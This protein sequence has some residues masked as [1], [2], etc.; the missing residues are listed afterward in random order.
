ML[1][2]KWS[3]RCSFGAIVAA[4]FFVFEPTA[5]A[6]IV[7]E[8]TD[9]AGDT[10]G[11]ELTWPKF[12]AEM[13]VRWR[14]GSVDLELFRNNSE[15]GNT[16]EFQLFQD[17]DAQLVGTSRTGT[18]EGDFV[19]R[20]EDAV[21]SMTRGILVVRANQV[22]GDLVLAGT[23]YRLRPTASGGV[24]ITEMNLTASPPAPPHEE[25]DPTGSYDATLRGGPI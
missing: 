17:V 13:V 14:V 16:L 5:L 11:A 15:P 22:S 2:K 9:D 8:C 19:W 4:A 21:D 1:A 12:P 18:G 10:E 25:Q 7:V 20:G 3:F 24:S 6:E 23:T